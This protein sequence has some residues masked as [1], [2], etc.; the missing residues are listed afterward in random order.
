M[1][2]VVVSAGVCDDVDD[3]RASWTD[4]ELMGV[5]SRCAERGFGEPRDSWIWSCSK[6]LRVWRVVSGLF[7]VDGI[8]SCVCFS[9]LC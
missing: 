5:L 6:C 8:D 4:C 9:A 7:H 3:V 2:S 1:T